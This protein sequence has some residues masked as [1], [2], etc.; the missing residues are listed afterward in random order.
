MHAS[1]KPSKDASDDVG[2]LSADYDI[3]QLLVPQESA[4]TASAKRAM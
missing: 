4:V 1:H 3:A 2:A